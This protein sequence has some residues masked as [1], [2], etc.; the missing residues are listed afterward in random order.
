MGEDKARQGYCT[1]LQRYDTG[2]VLAVQVYRDG[3][4]LEGEI[5]G[6]GLEPIRTTENDTGELSVS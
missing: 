5:I 2:D 3:T 4:G 1:V 6:R